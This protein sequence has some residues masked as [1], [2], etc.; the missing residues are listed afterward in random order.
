MAIRLRKVKEHWIALCAARSIAKRG[1]VYVG[2]AQ[3]EA[4]ANKF[5]RDS[6]FIAGCWDDAALVEIEESNNPNRT[7]WDKKFKK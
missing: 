1:D 4:L 3:H 2:D 6:K 7:W 5:A